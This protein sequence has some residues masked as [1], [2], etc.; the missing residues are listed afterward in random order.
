[1]GRNQAVDAWIPQLYPL[2]RRIAGGQLARERN[3]TLTPTGLVHEAFLKLCGQEALSLDDRA[4]FLSVAAM[5]MRRVL[6]DRARERLAHKRGGGALRV[7]LD[8]GLGL[9]VGDEDALS[10]H[11]AL[12]R[13]EAM[14]E[15]Q[16]K[17]V[18]YRFYGGLTDEEIA[19]VLGV[20]AP[21]VRRDWRVARAWLVRELAGGS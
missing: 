10:V 12:E 14:H 13:L 1:M 17:V 18:T 9:P 19:V 11:E 2:L 4:H 7:T 15:R 16:G 6:V 21:T 3:A 5:I 8:S 20:S